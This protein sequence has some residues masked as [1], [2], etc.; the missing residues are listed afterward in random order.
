MN[1]TS[2]SLLLRLRN[3]GEQEAW[4][5]F[6]QLYTPLIEGWVRPFGLSQQDAEELVQE[7][8]GKLVR[9]LPR[10]SYDRTRSFRAWLS[11]VTRNTVRSFVRRPRVKTMTNVQQP[12]DDLQ[13][14]VPC[15][16]EAEDFRRYVAHRAL[17][18]M[19]TDF[20]QTTWQAFWRMVVQGQ[21]GAEAAQ[22]LGIS[23]SAAYVA[24]HRVLR[25]LQEEL[26]GML[27]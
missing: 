14:D 2:I 24:K 8:F 10:F 21:S 12:L 5:R 1:T 3:P 17:V 26:A 6:V 4:F 16:I 15:L 25:R 18:V 27:E 19:Q 20:E 11:T 23:V 13:S 22:E 7:V 9:E